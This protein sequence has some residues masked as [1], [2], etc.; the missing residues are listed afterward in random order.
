MLTL[1]AANSAI[2]LTGS[3]TLRRYRLGAKSTVH[4][5]LKSLIAD[6]HM[7]AVSGG[8]GVD[9]PFFQRWIEVHTFKEFGFPT[10]ALIDRA[11]A[12]PR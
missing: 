10:S 2:E 8:H 3:A 4:R 6:E 7:V 1:I 12:E 5:I 9:D 11:Q